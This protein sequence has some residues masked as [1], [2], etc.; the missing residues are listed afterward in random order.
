MAEILNLETLSETARTYL[1]IR[2]GE[3]DLGAIGTSILQWA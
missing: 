1:T 2:M 3:I